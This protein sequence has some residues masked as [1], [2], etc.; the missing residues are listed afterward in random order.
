VPFPPPAL[1][2]D[3]ARPLS[4]GGDTG[5]N[6]VGTTMASMRASSAGR[7]SRGTLLKPSQ[8]PA[9]PSVDVVAPMQ[10][11]IGTPLSQV[12]QSDRGSTRSLHREPHDEAR[13]RRGR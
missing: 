13:A 11:A 6:P 9:A 1:V 12:R 8:G 5:S 10:L 2:T 3:S 7:S 4:Q